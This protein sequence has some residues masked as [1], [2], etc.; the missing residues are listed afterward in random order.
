MTNTQLT[1]RLLCTC[2]GEKNPMIKMPAHSEPLIQIFSTS[3]P[4]AQK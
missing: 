3:R 1:V 4:M 2:G